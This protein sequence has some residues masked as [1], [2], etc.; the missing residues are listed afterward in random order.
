[1]RGCGFHAL[2]L[3]VLLG[4][5]SYMLIAAEPAKETKAAPAAES[6]D[7]VL[8]NI[9]DKKAILVDVRSPKEW[10]EGH[11]DGAVHLPIGEWKQVAA[12][13]AKLKEYLAKNLPADKIVYVHCLVGFRAKLACNYATGSGYDL[14]PLVVNYADLVKAGFKE[15]K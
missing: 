10:K 7:A 8:K 14:R 4:L 5:G 13:P 6:L 3:S 12:D 15:V 11:L 1:M 2:L 9:A